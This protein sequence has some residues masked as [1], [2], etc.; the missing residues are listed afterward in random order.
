MRLWMTDSTVDSSTKTVWSG[1]RV[2]PDGSRTSRIAAPSRIRSPARAVASL[3]GRSLTKVP[4]ADSRSLTCSRPLAT[5]VI[6]QWRRDTDGSSICTSHCDVRPAVSVCP[7]CSGNTR[8]VLR[9]A[10]SRR[11]AI[12]GEP[13]YRTTI[14]ACRLL[15]RARSSRCHPRPVSAARRRHAEARRAGLARSLP[16]RG[17]PADRRSA[18]VG[19]RLAAPGAA[20]RHLRQSSQRIAEPRGRDQVGGRGD[21]EGRPRER[22]HRAGQGAALGARP[23]EPR[24]RRRRSRSRWSCSA[25][26]TASARR[27]PASRP[28]CWSSTASR[29]STPPPIASRDKI[30]LFNV[31]FTNYGDTVRFRATRPVARRRAR[32]RRRC[33]CARSARPACA[34]RTPARSRY[35]DGQP[36]IPAAALTTEDA[37]RLQR[38]VDR[39]TTVRLKLMM[40]AHFLPDADSVQRRR[41]DPRPRAARTRSSS[42]GGHFDSWDVGTGSTDDGG[43]CVVTW[44]ALRMMKKLNLRPRR[45]VRVVLWTN[46]ENG[47]RGG[48]AY[49]DQ[50]MT[51]LPNHVDDDRVRRRRVRADRLRVQRQRCRARQGPRHRDAARRHPRRRHRRRAAAAPTSGRAS[52]RPASRRCRLESNGNYFLI[53]HT[54]ADTIDKIDPL[55]MSRSAAAIAVMTYVIAEMPER[56]R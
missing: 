26:A 41:R 55:E 10:R 36:Q 12:R 6:V 4:L 45:T 22:A 44:E 29:S 31:P 16:R 18:V 23:R 17:Q 11:R 51:E 53:H 32:R 50:H 37:A 30:V 5:S 24:D 15:R 19:L 54:P 48:L 9:S 28:S 7:G 47:G 40:E 14:A 33:S 27:P 56:L 39:G 21:E 49:R 13:H 34:R 3:I 35:A 38:M 52:S 1:R 8:S 20:R 2:R 25:S 46:E 43:G 42:I